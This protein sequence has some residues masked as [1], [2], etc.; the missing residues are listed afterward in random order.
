[1]ALYFAANRWGSGK[2]I[3]NYKAEADQLLDAMK[4]REVI[5]GKTLRGT[6]TDGPEFNPQS[7][8]VRF[9]PNVGRQDFTDPSYHLPAFYELWARW[10][11]A[12]DRQFWLDAAAASRDLFSKVTGPETGL[13]PNQ[14][15]FDATPNGFGGR[16]SPFADDAWRT[17]ANWAMD[18]SWW[19]A[20]PR[21]R[22]LSDKIQTFFAARGDNY[23][24]RFTLDGKPTGNPTNNPHD[25]AL[26]ATNAV[27]GLAATDPA[28]EKKFVE[29]L[30]N[31]PIPSGQWRYYDGMWYI[32]GFLH[33]S[34]E[35]RIWQPK[36]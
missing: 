28:R 29:A 31:T 13:A 15:N 14:S 26:V 9:T 32:M 12:A 36:K 2:G 3:Y 25:T 35:F 24:T 5:T 30:W 21:E 33:C 34:G 8:M 1:M 10:G 17:E 19:N 16:T 20:D 18:W 6:E 22:Q 7:K 27:A 11:P 4:N 23:T